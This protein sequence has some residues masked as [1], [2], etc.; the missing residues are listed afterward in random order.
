MDPGT[1]LGVASLGLE[2]CKILLIFYQDFQSQNSD[3]K[4]VYD[5]IRRLGHL[6]E[7]CQVVIQ[8]VTANNDTRKTVDECLADCLEDVKELERQAKKLT[9]DPD[10]KTVFDKLKVGGRKLAYPFR[11]G[12]LQQLKGFVTNTLDSLAV[13]IDLLQLDISVD[14]S[15]ALKAQVADIL[16]QMNAI[17]N[18]IR[19]IDTTTQMIAKDVG[20]ALSIAQQ[21][22][23]DAALNWLNAP[24]PSTNHEEARKKHEEGTGEWFLASKEYKDWVEA[25]NRLGQAVL[26]QFG[27]FT[28]ETTEYRESTPC[29]TRDIREAMQR[30]QAVSVRLSEESINPDIQLFI[31]RRL[32]RDLN[33]DSGKKRFLLEHKTEIKEAFEQK[34][35]GM[36]RW[37]YCQLEEIKRAKYFRKIELSKVLAR[38]PSSLAETYERILLRLPEQCSRDVRKALIW[39]AFSRDHLTAQMLTEACITSPD[40][41][42]FV[43]E[44]SRDTMPEMLEVLS[45]L[46]QIEGQGDGEDKTEKNLAQRRVQLAHFSVKEFLVDSRTE[47]GP[48]SFFYLDIGTAQDFLAQSCSAYMIHC[49]EHHRGS[50][51]SRNEQPLLKYACDY[52]ISHKRAAEQRPVHTLTHQHHLRVLQDSRILVWWHRLSGIRVCGSWPP[53]VLAAF[54]NLPR[55]CLHLVQQTRAPDVEGPGDPSNPKLFERPG[56]TG[57]PLSTAARNGYMGIVELL[58]EHDADPN[59]TPRFPPLV[60]AVLGRNDDIA[61]ILLRQPT[62]D[63]SSALPNGSSALHHACRIGHTSLAMELIRRE[64]DVHSRTSYRETPLLVACGHNASPQL[65]RVLVDAGSDVTVRNTHGDSTIHQAALACRDDTADETTFM[66]RAGILIRHGCPVDSRNATGAT[67]LHAAA[68]TGNSRVVKVLIRLGLDVNTIDLAKS[69]LL[70]KLS[71]SSRGSTTQ[72]GVESVATLLSRGAD[73]DPHSHDAS[74]PTPL[75]VACQHKHI[76]E[77]ELLM[78][79]GAETRRPLAVV[80]RGGHGDSVTSKE[81]RDKARA[82]A[83]LL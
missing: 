16:H 50:A 22:E 61:R 76:T 44:G 20:T 24:D 1:A 41:N 10:L 78:D 21:Q 64:A 62:V 31:E 3:I 17:A 49:Y 82:V 43:D 46:L 37:A 40:E 19:T 63:V 81:E 15:A 33:F 6:F 30:N 42:P 52:W 47:N 18:S 73:V 68:S 34:A 58:F 27:A 53:L 70:W 71:A 74:V 4:E 57:S 28:D 67:A 54:C 75:E 55:T 59:F 60:S 32:E 2:V 7:Q 35:G 79:N 51:S 77:I 72:N 69:T 66:E 36:S 39:L 9:G 14:G 23:L 13:A 65:I 56:Q 83:R 80:E 11:R 25:E 8:R 26:D 45:S 5:S 29:S 12:T 48:A 38:L